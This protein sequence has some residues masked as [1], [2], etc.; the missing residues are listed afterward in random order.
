MKIESSYHGRR[1]AKF[2]VL[3][4]YEPP[5]LHF[6]GTKNHQLNLRGRN[7]FQSKQRMWRPK[8]ITKIRKSREKDWISFTL[9]EEKLQKENEKNFLNAKE[10]R[11]TRWTEEYTMRRSR[12]EG[13]MKKLDNIF[14]KYK[15]QMTM[16]DYLKQKVQ[17]RDP[18]LV[19]PLLPLKSEA[20]LTRNK[21]KNGKKG[22]RGKI[23]KG[24]KKNKNQV[25]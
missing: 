12:S 20:N 21:S 15:Q 2:S 7:F 14:E 22:N 13:A 3:E 11:E 1:D 16:T 19:R 18:A 17:T 25:L 24:K 10:E 9:E 23:K 4:K 6:F 8:P 5:R